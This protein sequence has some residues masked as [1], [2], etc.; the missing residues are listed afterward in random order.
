MKYAISFFFFLFL[1]TTFFGQY[2]SEFSEI[3]MLYSDFSIQSHEFL[4]DNLIDIHEANKL[5]KILESINLAEAQFIKTNNGLCEGNESKLIYINSKQSI[6]DN[7]A[8][9]FYK[10]TIELTICSKESNVNIPEIMHFDYLK[11]EIYG[12]E[13][14]NKFSKLVKTIDAVIIDETITNFEM[15]MVNNLS[16]DILEFK[17]SINDEFSEYDSK[18]KLLTFFDSQYAVIDSLMYQLYNKTIKFNFLSNFT[19]IYI[20]N[21]FFFKYKCPQY[22]FNKFLEMIER[23]AD[24]AIKFSIDKKLDDKEIEDLEFLA[25]ELDELEKYFEY[26]Y[27]DDAEG[28]AELDKYK[29]VHKADYDKIY[30]DFFNAI[31]DLYECEGADKLDF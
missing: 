20:P 5:N 24:L 6:I 15:N 26:K 29:A 10:T 16:D 3:E 7:I 30:D 23:Y 14:I 28:T 12:F 19:D 11:Q 25:N 17:I 8:D 9:S 22:D 21:D 2:D 18:L 1:S 31:M 4:K 27:K 13:L